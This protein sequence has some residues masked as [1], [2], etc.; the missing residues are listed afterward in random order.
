MLTYV[1]GLP[2]IW[3]GLLPAGVGLGCGGAGYDP[4]HIDDLRVITVVAD[5]PEAAPGASVGLTTWVADPGGEPA[6]IDVMLWTCL[7]L[8]DGS[9][10][11][12]QLVDEVEQWVTIGSAATGVMRTAREVPRETEQ[13]L[14][15]DG[16]PL[17]IQLFALACPV[18]SCGI[19]TDVSAAMD[20]VGI[21]PGIAAELADPSSWMVDLPMQGVS[22]ATREFYLSRRDPGSINKNPVFDARFAEALDDTITVAPGGVVDLAFQVNDPNGEFVYA[23]PFTTVGSFDR[24]KV[25]ADDGQVRLYLTAPPTASPTATQG[26]VWVVFDD[27][28]GGLAVYSQTVTVVA[29][30]AD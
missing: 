11:E 3:L 18:G 9:C 29:P 2:L 26:Q 23:Y 1:A 25:R 5:P 30:A 14:D 16:S 10:A 22:L 28:D 7:F 12:A 19:V 15:A 4:T 21:A 24:H 20:D 17:A 27:R 6:D 8:E 13:Y